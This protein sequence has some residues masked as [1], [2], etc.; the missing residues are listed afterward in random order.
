MVGYEKIRAR[1]GALLSQHSLE[2]PVE[3]LETIG[4]WLEME[5]PYQQD[6]KRHAFHAMGSIHAIEHAMKSLYPLLALSNRT[7][8]GGICYPLHPQL[9]KG[10]I[11]VYDYYPG[12]IGL[13]EK[14]FAMLDRLLDMT[15]NL[16]ET[17][18]A[19]AAAR[20]AFTFPPAAPATCRWTRRAASIC[21]SG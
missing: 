6:L 12:G 5:P 7:D 11:F 3:V 10:A 21:C 18:I 17:A 16:V 2:S 15:L 4:F 14:G 19:N 20:R 13:A 9:G 8:V 1:D